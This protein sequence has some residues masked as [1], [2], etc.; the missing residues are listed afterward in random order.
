MVPSPFAFA[1]IL[2]PTSM[3]RGS[4]RSFAKRE[5][6]RKVRGYWVLCG[7]VGLE[8]LTCVF[9]QKMAKEKTSGRIDQREVACRHEYASQCCS[10]WRVVTDQ[11]IPVYGCQR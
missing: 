5:S 10:Q 6:A 7:W 4:T 11:T 8:G 9:W 3:I 1:Q 2:S